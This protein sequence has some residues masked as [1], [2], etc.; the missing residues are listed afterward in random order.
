MKSGQSPRQSEVLEPARSNPRM[1]IRGPVA[2]SIPNPDLQIAEPPQDNILR[3]EDDGGRVLHIGDIGTRRSE[4][5]DP[6]FA[7]P[8][9]RGGDDT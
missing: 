9:I 3:W 2:F 8:T 7:A 1:P 5:R 6:D 4:H